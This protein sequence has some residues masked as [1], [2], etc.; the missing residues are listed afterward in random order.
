MENQKIN[1]KEISKTTESRN[2]D[3]VQAKKEEESSELIKKLKNET[4]TEFNTKEFEQDF[5]SV[6]IEEPFLGGVSLEITKRP[7]SRCSTAYVGVDISSLDLVLG[8]NPEFFRSLNKTERRGVIRHELYHVVFQH[9]LD[10]APLD[11]SLS[12]AF[13]ISADAA[14]NS[15]IGAQ[16][17]PE[18]GIIPGK[19]FPKRKDMSQLDKEIQ[20]FIE[21][22]PQLQ[23]TEAYF[24]E[25]KALIEKDKKRGG[26]GM[27]TIGGFDDHDLWGRLPQNVR[28]MLKE[29]VKNLICRSA[30]QS[31]AKNQW[32]SVPAEI[33]ERIRKMLSNEVD[34]RS[35]LRNFIGRC[36]TMERISTIKRLNKK[37]PFIY[38]GTK[39]NTTAN[40]VCFIDQSRSVSDED[41]CIFFGELEKFAEHT[42]LD[43]F[44][45]DTEIDFASHTVW[46]KGKKIEAKRTRC[47]GTR[48]NC[49]SEYL[50]KQEN[51]GKWSGAIIL[52]D[53][54]A[55][56][57]DHVVGTKILWLITPTGDAT[58]AIRSGNYVCHMSKE[59]TF[60][61]V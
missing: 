12:M 23:A 13:N 15:I 34:W 17:L 52:T 7:D 21:K 19:K 14:I 29:K 53:G 30:K 44:H 42:N 54:F 57:I 58:G 50:N 18:I 2:N 55:E 39:R 36:R 33:Q 56:R 28:D 51:R 35:V 45:F 31:D 24:E 10:R 49:V 6:Y 26:D 37:V 9:I 25:I 48:F 47:G 5:L 61:A 43:V 41:I 38:P 11:R 8:Y 60:H 22:A 20:D 27:I 1:Q 3:S 16:N 59:K 40:F 32:G 46:K 4:N